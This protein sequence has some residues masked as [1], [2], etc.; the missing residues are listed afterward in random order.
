MA[1]C[2]ARN[3]CAKFIHLSYSDEL[4]LDN[5]SKCRET[6]QSAEFQDLWPISIKQDADSK[7]KWYTTAGGGVYATSAGGAVTGFGAGSLADISSQIGG[8][9]DASEFDYYFN[10]Q[11]PQAVDPNKFYGAIIIDDPIKVDDAY[12]Q[13]ERQKVN[14]RLNT[15]IKS[16]RNSRNTPIIIIMQRLHEDDMSGYVLSGG[17]DEPFYHLKIPACDEEAGISMW[18]EKHT[19]EE[20]MRFKRSNH[21]VF[22]AQYQ[23]DPTPEGGS[24]FQA[25][26]FE[27]NRFRLGQEPFRLVKYG[28]GDYAVSENTGDW[29]EQA[30]A[31][32]DSSDNLYFLDWH[33]ARVTLDKSIDQLLQMA[34]QHDPIFWAAE[35][36]VIRRSMEPFLN[37]EM[38]RRRIYPRMKW[39]P[40]TK[41]KA[42]N[43]RSFQAL[44]AAGK[45][46][47]PFG[48]WG[49]DLIAQL[50]RFTGM[51]DKIDDKVDVCGIM[52]RI[53]DQADSPSVHRDQ[54]SGGKDAYGRSDDWESA[55]NGGGTIPIV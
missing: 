10:D 27:N 53:L 36:G 37:K 19:F 7:K 55:E 4:A 24:F 47:I 34:L 46:Y 48:Q 8:D 42:A 21:N 32:F 33:S 25:E 30:I 26:W 44:A 38:Q 52:G 45:V 16:R 18:P 29:T 41:S 43:A 15:T 20:L 12:S 13:R 5:S 54:F 51:G 2:L 6:V 28:A 17:M 35:T 40:A 11:P 49:D 23:Q 3:P 50:L 14:Q 39:L 22:M 9:D 31:G 1:R